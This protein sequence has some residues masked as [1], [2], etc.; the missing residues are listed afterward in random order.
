M[1]G[2]GGNGGNA[3]TVNVRTGSHRLLVRKEG[4][5]AM[6]EDGPGRRGG[7]CSGR[8]RLS[9]LPRRCDCNV[10]LNSRAEDSAAPNANESNAGTHKLHIVPVGSCRLGLGAKLAKP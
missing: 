5:R 1:R 6:R 10:V 7:E 4:M 8:G 2:D 3:E 9:H